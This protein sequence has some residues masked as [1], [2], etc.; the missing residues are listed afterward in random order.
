MRDDERAHVPEALGSAPD[1]PAADRSRTGNVRER[2]RLGTEHVRSIANARQLDILLPVLAFAALA[3]ALTTQ[4]AFSEQVS[5]VSL[6]S[7]FSVAAGLIVAVAVIQAL[8]SPA[9]ASP[10]QA[11]VLPRRVEHSLLAAVVAIAA[12]FRFYRFF[13]FPPGI[14]FDEGVTAVDALYI[15][16]EDHFT[17]WRDTNFGRPTLY[18]YLL[19]GSFTVFGQTVFALR[20]VPAFAGLAAVVVFYLLCRRIT[21][22]VPALL[23]TAL[24]ATSRWA[25]SFSRIS[26][27][28]SMVPLF[29][30][31]SA[32]F[33]I[34][35]L[36]TRTRFYFALAGATLAA[37]L[38]TYVAF[39][40]VP[41]VMLMF[42][43]YAGITEWRL[44]RRSIAGLL[45]YGIAFLVVIA[46]LAHFSITHSEQVLSRT[47]EI[48]VFR[49]IDVEDSWEPLRFNIRANIQVMNVRGDP[50]G[51][52]NIPGTPMLDE[53]TAAL[54]VLGLAVGAASIWN[55][56]RGG[57]ALWYVLALVPGALS[58]STENP[59]AIRTIG[60]LPP[61]YLLIG[62]A[63]ATMH[64]AFAPTRAGLALFAA[65]SLWLVG[66][67]A[68][69]NYHDF[70]ERQAPHQ[71]TYDGYTPAY[72]QVGE[73]IGE[74]GGSERYHI[75]HQFA[76]HPAI[77]L[78]ADGTSYERYNPGTELIFEGGGQP[79]VL[80]ADERQFGIIATL[81]RLYPQMTVDEH[82]NPFGRTSFVRLTLPIQD[83]A[84]LHE[85]PL[86]ITRPSGITEETRGRLDRSWTADDLSE[87]PFLASW[88]AHYWSTGTEGAVS[89]QLV[90]GG[91]VSIEIDG[92]RF[93][94]SSGEL[95]PPPFSWP[96]GEHH[97]RI[98]ARIER[99][100]SI[101][102]YV[103]ANQGRSGAADAL[104]GTSAGDRG[105][106]VL[107]REGEDFAADAIERSHIPFAVP[108]AR[109]GS[110]GGIEYQGILDVPGSGSYSFALDGYSSQLVVD[111][112]IV[113]DNGGAHSPQRVEGV[114]EL[115]G[116]EHLVSVQYTVAANEPVLGIYMRRPAEDWSV[117]D[118]SEFR[119]PAADYVP[120][121]LVRLTPDASGATDGV[122]L[123]DGLDGVR[124]IDVFSDG[125]IVV[126]T[127]DRIALVSSE[128][129]VTSVIED[130]GEEI[131][132]VAALADGGIVAMDAATRAMI[133]LNPDGSVRARY[134][135]QSAAGVGGAA[136]RVYAASPNG[137]LVYRVTLADGR[138]DASMIPELRQP[139]DIAV[140]PD[141]AIYIADLET[142]NILRS[143]DGVTVAASF[144][145]VR[146]SGLQLPHLAVSADLLF[147]TDPI[148]RRVLIYDRATGRQRGAYHFPAGVHAEPRGVA[149]S[150]DGRVY[151]VDVIGGGVYRFTPTLT[152][153]P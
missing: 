73:M 14:W 54:F 141:G 94:S 49:E 119:V 45:L 61:L 91:P 27:E 58:I 117:V 15:L 149:A 114:I 100:A 124:S 120:P 1:P 111:G 144:A 87:G 109:Y 59:S 128:G 140:A 130:V 99:P 63:L 98:E 60:V 93:E 4:V 86:T 107:Y 67:C 57:V 34:L 68:A 72:M 95:I 147:V 21:G 90:N 84:A 43:V 44:I 116:G 113:V 38:Y 48:N 6:R 5:F 135:L 80:I 22:P 127:K 148:F 64:R 77:T 76:G 46:P 25:V 97:I 85:L 142:R 17:V 104:Y 151:V 129:A 150:P 56:R 12:F 110:A 146:G 153:P 79:H 30:T 7:G 133:V 137:G 96:P 78:L 32:Y 118:G 23:A 143:D 47:R 65:L 29:A 28:A 131:F 55:W 106:R 75:S 19:A 102:S 122:R 82:R 145:G 42:L 152:A 50:N 10:A 36:E 2:V 74:R 11:L 134:E 51:R 66:T 69:I 62:L 136:D 108:V 81:R 89:F 121:G 33:L 71:Y 35:A 52:H 139:A 115:E 83:L 37:G 20:V 92:E 18:L 88:E 31:M 70:F 126:A 9:E 132:D 8:R 3:I 13:D 101:A 103:I 105:F 53:V 41:V 138:L 123:I 39:R 125:S 16:N 26:W 112:Q 40:I 24:F